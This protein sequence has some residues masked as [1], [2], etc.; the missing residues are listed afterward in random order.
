MKFHFHGPS[1]VGLIGAALVALPLIAYG[2]PPMGGTAADTNGA[3]SSGTA[4]HGSAMM[5]GGGAKGGMETGGAMNGGA[6]KGGTRHGR[7]AMS[8]HHA[9]SGGEV[10]ELQEALN[11][12]GASLHVDG[13]M[14][15]H[16]R[17]ALHHYQSQNGLKATGRIDSR[18]KQ[19]LNIGS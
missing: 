5:N 15:P 3:T 8:G 14:G 16:T 7:T 4:T 9:R 12:K 18:T 10:R 13:I 19:K 2:A 11:R 17:Q 1:R 6:M